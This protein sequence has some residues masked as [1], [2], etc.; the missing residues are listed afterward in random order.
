[1]QQ[2]VVRQTIEQTADRGEHAKIRLGEW[3][4]P[5]KESKMLPSF[6]NPTVKI[7][8]E[9]EAYGP[10]TISVNKSMYFSVEAYGKEKRFLVTA[11]HKPITVTFLPRTGNHGDYW[12]LTGE[13]APMLLTVELEDIPK[14]LVYQTKDRYRRLFDTT[15]LRCY[16]EIP[17]ASGNALL[18]SSTHVSGSIIGDQRT[19]LQQHFGIFWREEGLSRKE[20]VNIYFADNQPNLFKQVRIKFKKTFRQKGGGES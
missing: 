11:G 16:L 15:G 20:N 14:H 8:F 12:T 2:E 5:F 1:M 17:V 10:G 4:S 19:M 7:P 13:R 6:K 9:L 3:L 18:S